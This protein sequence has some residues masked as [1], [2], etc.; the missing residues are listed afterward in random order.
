M[1][2]AYKPS[3][4][5]R[6]AHCVLLGVAL[7]LSPGCSEETPTAAVPVL[8]IASPHNDFIQ[9]EFAVA[10]REWHKQEFG[11]DVEVKYQQR[12]GTAEVV[13]YVVSEFEA[14]QAAGDADAGIGIDIVFGGGIPAALRL[15]EAG[16]TLPVTVGDDVLAA[17]PATLGGIPLRGPEGHWYGNVLTAFG[18][19]YNKKALAKAGVSEPKTWTDLASESYFG[20]VILADPNKSASISVCFELVLQ[21]YGWERGWATLMRIA[22]NTREFKPTS[23]QVAP[24]VA[25][26]VGFA[27]M[28]IAFYGHSQIAK[29]GADVVG[30]VS[31]VGATAMT[32]DPIVVLRGCRD[33]ELATRFVTF[34]LTEQAQALWALPAG[35]PGG[36]KAETLYRIPAIPGVYEKYGDRMVVQVRPFRDVG[37]FRHDAQTEAKRRSLIGPLISA[38]FLKNLELS[39]RAW[40]V[41]IDSGYDEAL[42]AAFERPPF[43]EEDGLRL[44]QEHKADSRRAL[45]LDQQWYKFFRE[46]YERIL[47]TAKR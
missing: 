18:I 19:V 11:Q 39:R 22:A 12:G 21:R 31:P 5:L 36:P 40:R 23:S 47:A 1:P 9:T 30:Y 43:T 46:K 24:D 4:E 45:E 32:P 29:S 13:R 2:R 38:A 37:T 28:S 20:R 17:Q 25:Q 3:P 16:C 41:V 7:I 15:K 44:G 10:F 26:G 33:A 8:T 6:R 35:T 34:T 42:V 27:G 14:R